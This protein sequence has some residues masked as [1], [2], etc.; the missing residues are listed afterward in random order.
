M[1][2]LCLVLEAPG[3]PERQGQRMAG[4]RIARLDQAP[5]YMGTIVAILDMWDGDQ[6][7]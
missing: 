6:A 2:A 4:K 3:L 5:H 7:F 1:Q